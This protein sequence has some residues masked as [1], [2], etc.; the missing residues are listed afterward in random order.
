MVATRDVKIIV[1]KEKGKSFVPEQEC[2]FLQVL[3]DWIRDN[4]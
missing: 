1:S 2:S 3:Q 4:S